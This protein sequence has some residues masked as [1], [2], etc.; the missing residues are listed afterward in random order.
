MDIDIPSYH[1]EGMG[2]GL[3]DKRIT[4]RYEACQYG[5]ETAVEDCTNDCIN[6]LQERVVE[7]EKAL[8]HI[9]GMCGIVNSG[10]ACRAI[11]TKIGEVTD[12]S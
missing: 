5:Y 9:A 7:L 4:D 3:E 2:C 6:P 1:Y 10:D 12:E 11:L 8:K